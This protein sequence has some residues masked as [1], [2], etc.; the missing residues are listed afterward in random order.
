MPRSGIAGSYGNYIFSFLRN[1]HTILY[2][3]YTNLHS[4]PGVGGFPF[5]HTPSSI[6]NDFLND[7]HSDRCEVVPHCSFD[8]ISLIISNVD[9][10]FMCLLAISISSLEK[11]LFRSSAHVLIGLFVC[12]FVC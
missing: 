4:H 12:L 3:G 11:C 10:L 2:S 7:G 9:H 8:C 6:F 5:L 1:L